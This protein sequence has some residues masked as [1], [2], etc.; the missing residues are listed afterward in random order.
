MPV[1]DPWRAM[2]ERIDDAA[3]L[4]GLDEDIHRMLRKPRRVLEVSI[5]IISVSDAPPASIPVR[6]F[7]SENPPADALLK[8]LNPSGGIPLTAIYAPG[9]DQPIQISSVY[10]TQT[11]LKV[12]E[13]LSRKSVADAR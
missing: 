13:E 9:S 3:K 4:T 11:L 10:T 1:S 7:T 12:L 5:P 2:L 6:P 8:T